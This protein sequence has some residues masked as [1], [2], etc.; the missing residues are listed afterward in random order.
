MARDSEKKARREG[1]GLLKSP[2][3][4]LLSE[5]EISQGD[6]C[7][8]LAFGDAVAGEGE[9]FFTQRE[10]QAFLIAPILIGS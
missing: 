1:A 7:Q 2:S 4:T 6:G 9:H 10:L 3:E 8:L 5:T